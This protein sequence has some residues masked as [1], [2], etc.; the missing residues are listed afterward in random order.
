[1]SPPT[2]F[3]FL[4]LGAIIQEFK[5]Q[6]HNIVQGFQNIEHYRDAPFFGETI[7]RTS[8]R[9]KNG[10]IDSLNG[11]SYK[12]AQNNYPN[13]LHGGAI[14]FGKRQFE[15]KGPQTHQDDV[16]EK[17]LFTYQ[18]PDGEEG[19]PGTVELRVWY[20]TWEETDNGFTKTCLD[21]EYEVEMI[22]HECEE[23]AVSITN[24]R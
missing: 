3:K 11:R 13:S 2:Q 15:A 23:T 19:Y 24:H 16:A 7:G 1:M 14:G 8:N 17:V 12:L 22:G 21:A 9:I 4:P 10:T 20:T 18:S 6:G 5:V